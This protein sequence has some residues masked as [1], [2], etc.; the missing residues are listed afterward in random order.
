MT[1]FVR[2][3]RATKDYAGRHGYTWAAVMPLG[4]LTLAGAAWLIRRRKAAG[5]KAE[6]DPSG[7]SR[8]GIFM[9]KELLVSSSP[10][11]TKVAV[12]EDDQL[13]EVYFQ[14]DLDSGLVGG[15]YKGRVNR[16]L[17]GM[18]S[19]FVDIGLE[20]DAFLYV[21]DFF[22]DSEEYDRVFTDAENRVA[23]AAGEPLTA[24]DLPRAETVTTAN[25]MDAGNAQAFSE[26]ESAPVALDLQQEQAPSPAAPASADA[27]ALPA[28]ATARS[29]LAMP[30]ETKI[31]QRDFQ[32]RESLRR[33]SPG[34]RHRRRGRGFRENR[35]S[36]RRESEKEKTPDA[37]SY[38]DTR[39]LEPL[40]GESL[41]KYSHAAQPETAHS[42][43]SQNV[44]HLSEDQDQDHVERGDP[45]LQPV[46]EAHDFD[47]AVSEAPPETAVPLSGEIETSFAANAD[48]DDDTVES[49]GEPDSESQL[50][51]ANSDWA[52]EIAE[53]KR[54]DQLGVASGEPT[55]ESLAEAPQE[56]EKAFED[57]ESTVSAPEPEDENAFSPS[58]NGEEAAKAGVTA[59]P[60]E[61]T[62]TIPAQTYTLRDSHSH[63]RVAPRRGRK[64]SGRGRFRGQH[65]RK[66]D[67]GGAE[68]SRG[69]NHQPLPINELLKEGQEILVQIA[70]EPLGTK[71]ARITSHIALPGRYL[72]YMPTITHIGVSRK[73]GSD[74]E[75]LRLRNIILENRGSLTGGF[76]VRTAGA[77]R[78]EDELKADLAFLTNLWNEIRARAERSKAPALLHR[79][80]TLVERI[81]RDL[82]SPDF[83]C[84]RVDNEIEYEHVLDF[85]NRFQ[86]ALIGHV[87]LYT[88]DAPLFEEFGIQAE[89]DKALKPKVW[90]KSGGYIVIN[91]TEALVAIDV[92]T[93][94]YVGKT[95]RL[96]DTI[97]KTNID[98][99][100]EIVR[101][102]RLRDLGGII[103]I[104]FI[105]MDE[106]RN[107]VKVVQALED[108]LRRDR[109]PTKILAFNEFG[110]V[111]LT[112][113]RA[114][115]S[116][117][118]TLCEPCAQCSGAGWVKSV[119][120]VS[121]E[122]VAEAR[123]MAS[124]IDG[125]SMTLRVNPQVA[126]NLKSK[127]GI[128]LSEIEASSRKEVII[129][130][131]PTVPQERFEIF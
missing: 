22:E 36:F 24:V 65:G 118:R 26:G 33:D 127:D 124:Q 15:I 93:G 128:L 129:K 13:V 107:R 99:V 74:E 51:G 75:R 69:G 9:T 30:A 113:K 102:I 28:D 126:A 77:G 4:A 79:D 114:K 31:E 86:P 21:S 52:L 91:Q 18:Q 123:K 61:A 105:D 121:N 98:A 7:N 23:K 27:Q 80:L 50:A 97:V 3:R 8:K 71:G 78:S 29:S 64:G 125:K 53:E 85:V 48:S 109:A 100:M 17:P 46:I 89:I 68:R 34:R 45:S 5:D 103:V 122:I 20:R 40:P 120:T 59:E 106:R 1:V 110:L 43:E 19:A 117:E 81:L 60:V 73:I 35:F 101:Q 57:N 12:L 16:V 38:L 10:H 94:K 44:P 47:H 83:K 90:L 108:A 119:A 39:P 37:Q 55:E 130:S 63:A 67:A 2:L 66:P 84:L 41:A 56:Q 87:K 6:V 70:K 92:N 42:L 72:V 58:I 14:R 11:E 116:L 54:I 96:E 62:E 88:R 32:P 76:I 25:P 112:R 115:Q 104:D 82:L 95:N 131:D 111:A 49:S